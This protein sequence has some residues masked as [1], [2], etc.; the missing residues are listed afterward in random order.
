MC[1][2]HLG[3]YHSSAVINGMPEPSLLGFLP[4]KTPHFIHFHF[5]YFVDLNADLSWIPMLDG[6]IVDMLE[7]MLFFL[8][9]Q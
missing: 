4:N 8:T 6:W 2:Q 7:L 5:F 1:P 9:L 3:Y